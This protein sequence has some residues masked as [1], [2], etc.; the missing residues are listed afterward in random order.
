L[1]IRPKTIKLLEENR[2]GK[3]HDVGLGNNFFNLTPKTKATKAKVNRWDYIKLKSFCT[4]EETKN[5]MK[6]QPIK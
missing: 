2:S 6:R 3:L 4:T 5:K 1:N